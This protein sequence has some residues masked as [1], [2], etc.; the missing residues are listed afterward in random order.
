MT[1]LS[2]QPLTVLSPSVEEPIEGLPPGFGEGLAGRVAYLHR[3]RLL[4]L[5]ALDRRLWHAAQPGGAGHA[6]RLPAAARLRPHR[7]PAGRSRR[8][9]RPVLWALGIAGFLTGLYNWV[10]YADLIQR[11]G[12]PHHARPDRRRRADRARLRRREAAHGP[13]ADHH[14]RRSSSPTASSASTCRRP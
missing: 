13:A 2:H 1:N 8:P 11:V 12:L 3:R 5:P 6:C 14:V 10:F 9:A 7:Q 4:R